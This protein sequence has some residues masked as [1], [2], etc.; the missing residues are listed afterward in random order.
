[1]DHL[2][3]IPLY[4]NVFVTKLIIDAFDV[5]KELRAKE[6]IRFHNVISKSFLYLIRNYKNITQC[7]NISK[8]LYYIM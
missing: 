7:Y 3:H 2:P 6:D 1:M 5:F 8:L 4:S